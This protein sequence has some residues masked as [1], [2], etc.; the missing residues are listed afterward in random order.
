MCIRDRLNEKSAKAFKEFDRDTLSDEQKETYDIYSYMLD[1]TTEMNDSKF[2]YMSM[3]LESMTGM[4]TP[5]SYT[6]LDVYKR[7][8]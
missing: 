1:Y 4:H 5:V 3:P 6:H 8:W 7:Q 2:D